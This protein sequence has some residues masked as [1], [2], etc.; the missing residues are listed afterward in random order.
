MSE[1]DGYFRVATTR[2]KMTLEY[3]KGEYYDFGDS[4]AEGQD[5]TPKLAEYGY[6]DYKDNTI[7]N[8]LYVFDLEG[9]LVFL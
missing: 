2:N 6:Y 3:T 4:Y 8:I 1:Y 9:T 7:D 5:S